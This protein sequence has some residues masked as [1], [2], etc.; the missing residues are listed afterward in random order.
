MAIRSLNPTAR[1]RGIEL[2]YDQGD[3][4]PMALINQELVFIMIAFYPRLMIME[5]IMI[6]EVLRN[7]DSLL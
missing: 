2:A 7:P 4:V 1:D 6:M 5:P 3:E